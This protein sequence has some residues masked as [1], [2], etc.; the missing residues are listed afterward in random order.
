MEYY[1]KASVWK[2]A[3]IWLLWLYIV[4]TP[5]MTIT[6]IELLHLFLSRMLLKFPEQTKDN[7]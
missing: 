6:C 3:V 1:L 2:T 4:M 7:K 5:L